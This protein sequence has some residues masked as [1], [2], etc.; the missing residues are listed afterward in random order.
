[1][2]FSQL[3]FD[4]SI[5]IIG[6]GQLGLMMVLESAGLGVRFNV[7]GNTS[8][9]V[10]RYAKCYDNSEYERF[11]EESSIV[12][13]EW[14]QGNG[15]AMLLA[16]EE[17][18]L[19]PEYGNVWMKIER[20][21]EKEFL[22]RK[23]FPVARFTVVENGREAIKA[24][25][26]E[27]NWNAVIK[28]VSGGYDGK[29]QLYVRNE[30]YDP[31]VEKISGRLVVEEFVDFDYESS[32][33]LARSGEEMSYYPVSYNFNSDGILVYNYGPIRDSG[34]R[35]IAGKLA[36]SL[37]Y[38]GVMG[39]EF[40]VRDGKAIINE[41][42][43]RVHNSGHYTI[44]SSVTSQFENHVRA[45]T[46]LPLGST[47]T[48]SFFGMVNILGKSFV[49]AGIARQGNVFLYGKESTSPRR[50]VGHVNVSGNSIDD[51]RGKI[52]RIIGELYGNDLSF[53]RT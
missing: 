24:V 35:E 29:G 15:N 25:R 40:F 10:C 18:K 19:V 26:D 46:S 8:D 1:M 9:P 7:L 6:S 31:A 34:E 28:R 12:T 4:G 49:N 45:I 47:S 32:I 5:G 11:V 42:S 2:K 16:S 22:S 14:E 21:R 13:Y 3:P 39:V 27:F 30:K 48:P 44:N 53:L 23:G 43:P 17:G 50:K 38:R 20:D 51:V 52:E 36:E 33:I 37:G 41:L